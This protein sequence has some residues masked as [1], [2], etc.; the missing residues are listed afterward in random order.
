MTKNMSYLN[1]SRR[2]SQIMDVIYRLG[3]ANVAEVLAE[4][5]DPPGYNSVRVILNILENKGYLKH[6]K[7]G[8]R[9]I[10][11]PIQV[12]DKAR[13]SMLKHL[14]ATLFHGSPTL[15]LSTLL[16]LSAAELTDKEIEELS[17]MIEQAKKESEK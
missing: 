6:H 9:Y 7:V 1:L 12:L 16:D 2:E 5:D 17:Q 11:Q 15:V 14:L 4:M 3:E 8:Q 10:Y 13:R